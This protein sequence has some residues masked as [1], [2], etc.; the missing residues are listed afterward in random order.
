[1]A[2]RY[3]ISFETDDLLDSFEKLA[4]LKKEQVMDYIIR[5]EVLVNNLKLANT[6]VDDHRAKRALFNG[7]KVRPD[8]ETKISQELIGVVN[9]SLVGTNISVLAKRTPQNRDIAS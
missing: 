8:L 3:P 7:L 1:M 5:F 9:L 6:P 2:Y 4:L